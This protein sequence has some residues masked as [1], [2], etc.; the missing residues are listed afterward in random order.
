MASECPSETLTIFDLSCR[1]VWL[2][3]ELGVLARDCH[4]YRKLPQ[5]TPRACTRIAV[6]R[7][8]VMRAP[9][10]FSPRDTSIVT[11]PSVISRCAIKGI[12]PR[13][14]YRPPDVALILLR[15][16]RARSTVTTWS[17][18][19]R[20]SKAQTPPVNWRRRHARLR[21]ASSVWSQRRCLWPRPGDSP[22]TSCT[23]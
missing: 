1:A 23:G 16:S 6:S 22:S 17:T 12:L 18:T 20:T 4:R 2:E 21:G 14:G 10:K 11:A 8:L 7:R 5:A 19:T 9:S 3:A 13:T 15:P